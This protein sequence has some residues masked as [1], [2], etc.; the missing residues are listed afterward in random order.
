MIAVF[1][2]DTNVLVR[3]LTQDDPRQARIATEL[4]ERELSAENP[5]FITSIALCE[6]TF[7]LARSYKLAR[8]QIADIIERLLSVDRLEHEHKA[9]A[10]L[11]VED[12]RAHGFDF[13]DCL[14]AQIGAQ[15]GYAVFVSFD[16]ALAR[17]EGVRLLG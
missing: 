5:G 7:V 6:L 12:V 14:M 9:A 15:H 13:A 16:A 3:Y 2:L 17:R 10:A 1:C 4:L 8:A 11:A